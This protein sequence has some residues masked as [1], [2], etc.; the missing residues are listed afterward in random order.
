MN[1]IGNNS[2]STGTIKRIAKL[3]RV[4]RD[5]SKGWWVQWPY[6]NFRED[7]LDRYYRVEHWRATPDSQT[8]CRRN[9][10]KAVVLTTKIKV[11][12]RRL[13]LTQVKVQQDAD[14]V[15]ALLFHRCNN[16][17]IFRR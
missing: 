3:W 5:R 16:F 7:E 11:F 14:A 9:I 1:D 12:L 6:D 13:W 2:E 17:I 4:F 15:T 8:R 10:Y